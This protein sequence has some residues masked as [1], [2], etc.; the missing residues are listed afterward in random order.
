MAFIRNKV[1]FPTDLSEQSLSALE[2][3]LEI[4]EDPSRLHVVSVIHP[5]KLARVSFDTEKD[6]IHP[7]ELELKEALEKQGVQNANIYVRVGNPGNEIVFLVE[8]INADLVVLGS[9]GLDCPMPGS[10]KKVAIGSVAER[11]IRQAPCP[12]LVIRC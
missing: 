4:V 8:E 9:H 5:I 6:I 1:V 7:R 12:V 11:V 2:T 10:G 3:A